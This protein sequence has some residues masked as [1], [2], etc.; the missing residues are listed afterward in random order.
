MVSGWRDSWVRDGWERQRGSKQGSYIQADC[1][2]PGLAA[3]IRRLTAIAIMWWSWQGEWSRRE[4]RVITSALLLLHLTLSTT[5]AFF[6]HATRACSLACSVSQ[7]DTFCPRLAVDFINTWQMR[8]RSAYNP[9][10]QKLVDL[11]PC[12]TA[13]R[14][15]LAV[16]SGL[17]AAAAHRPDT[18]S[19]QR[20]HGGLV[21]YATD[22]VEADRYQDVYRISKFDIRIN[23]KSI[24][25]SLSVTTYSHSNRQSTEFVNTDRFRVTF[26]THTGDSLERWP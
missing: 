26:F 24:L 23:E 2:V 17:W 7:R 1:A 8:L 11:S 9:R 6:T 10:P 15:S 14:S 12:P 16:T 3:E 19:R 13:D 21:T 5:D 22:C 18:D 4:R 20:S 25:T